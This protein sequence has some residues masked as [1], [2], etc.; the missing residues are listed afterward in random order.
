MLCFDNTRIELHI[1]A[2]KPPS[3]LIFIEV[4][5][6]YTSV[7]ISTLQKDKSAMCCSFLNFLPI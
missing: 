5:L 4:W 3:L 7:F 1:K 2:S 6:L